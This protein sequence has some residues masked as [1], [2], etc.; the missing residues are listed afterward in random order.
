MGT[1]W[2][3]YAE[4]AALGFEYKLALGLTAQLLARR[5]PMLESLTVGDLSTEGPKRDWRVATLEFVKLLVDALPRLPNVSYNARWKELLLTVPER[6]VPSRVSAIRWSQVECLNFRLTFC[7][8]QY[9]VFDV[10]VEI[11][12]RKDET[13]ARRSAAGKKANAVKRAKEGVVKAS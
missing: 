12:N 1:F 6:A 2:Y 11:K 5:C 7:V 3:K 4:A 13:K 10:D 9:T 8:T